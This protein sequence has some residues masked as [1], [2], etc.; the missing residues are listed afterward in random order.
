MIVSINGKIT[1]EKK[2]CIPITSD[3]FLF[4]Y[5]A[6]ETIRTYKEKIFR[7][8]DHLA[9]LFVSADILGIKPKWTFEKAYKEVVRTLEK[10]KGWRDTK[11]RLILTKDDF[12]VMMEKIKE[13]PADMYK[14]GVKLVS[15][16]GKRNLPHAKKLADVFSYVAK[17][18]ALSCGVYEAVLVDPKTYVRECAYA[19]IFW[20]NGGEVYTTNKEILFGITRET[21][22]ELAE[23]CRFEGIKFKSLTNADE[24]FLTQTTSG[25]LPVSEIN[26]QKIGSGR[27][28]SITKQLMKK[29]EKLVWGKAKH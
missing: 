17:Q 11:M 5:A 25:I 29:F 3:A 1:D 28:G 26:G 14:K 8:D 2:A 18:H 16:H 9:R 19:N 15:F 10:K 22:I 7:L 4:G 6:F 20:V 27:P 13:K 21:V 12:I 24:V 23:D